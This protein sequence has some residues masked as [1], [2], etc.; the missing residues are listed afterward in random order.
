MTPSSERLKFCYHG[1]GTKGKGN[2]INEDYPLKRS[3]VQ[4]KAD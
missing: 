4:T 3:P 1:D 2:F